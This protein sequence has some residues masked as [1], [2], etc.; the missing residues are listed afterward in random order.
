MKIRGGFTALLAVLSMLVSVDAR[1]EDGGFEAGLRTGFGWP[2]GRATD[3]DTRDIND[4]TSGIV[5]LWV[6]LGARMGPRVLLGGYFQFGF[7]LIGD[8][9]EQA[10]EASGADCST[11]STRFGAQI[12]YHF[13]PEHLMDPW[14][15]YGV[16]WEWWHLG[17]EAPAG[18]IDFVASGFEFANFQV[19][20]DL[21]PAPHVY[22]GP[23]VS[24]SLDQFVTVDEN[25]SGASSCPLGNGD[26]EEKSLHQWLVIGVR[27][28]FTGFSP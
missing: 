25:C 3:P 13:R 8:D 21:R 10:C 18:T 20:L 2:F 14:L 22:V 12:H 1:A 7:G 4:A 16:G 5:P 24:F 11:S 9:L 26:I 17:V 6:D 27:G 19:G 15:G 23:F 28:G